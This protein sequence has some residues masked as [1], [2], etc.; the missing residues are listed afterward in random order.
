MDYKLYFIEILWFLKW[1]LLIS[2]QVPSLETCQV[3]PKDVLFCLYVAV[4][5]A[6]I[7]VLSQQCYMFKAVLS[8]QKIVGQFT[9]ESTKPKE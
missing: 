5:N 4:Q 6:E 1:C 8:C 7:F 2:S 3:V 9:V